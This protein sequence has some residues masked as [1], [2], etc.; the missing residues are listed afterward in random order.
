M[1]SSACRFRSS[2]FMIQLPPEK[3]GLQ[4]KAIFSM[5][6]NIGVQPIGFEPTTVYRPTMYN[7][8]AT[9]LLHIQCI[10]SDLISV[11]VSAEENDIYDR[12]INK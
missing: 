1:P 7:N 9:I 10:A 12:P 5:F 11:H 2:Q 3:I 6:Y 4:V 8:L